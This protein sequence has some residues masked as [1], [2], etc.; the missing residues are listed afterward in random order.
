MRLDFGT[1]GTFG[2]TVRD[3]PGFTK[4]QR[5]I[6]L[7]EVTSNTIPNI[8]DLVFGLFPGGTDYVLDNSKR[9]RVMVINT[10]EVYGSYHGIS[11]T[12][13]RNVY[14][15]HGMAQCSLNEV[16][17]ETPILFT[18]VDWNVISD[19]PDSIMCGKR[20]GK[21]YN[22]VGE[23]NV[24]YDNNISGGTIY[25][26]GVSKSSE[27]L[28]PSPEFYDEKDMVL[29][30]DREENYYTKVLDNKENMYFMPEDKY[31]DTL[32]TLR[33]NDLIDSNT[34]ICKLNIKIENLSTI[35]TN[36]D[37]LENY[38]SEVCS[39]VKYALEKYGFSSGEIIFDGKNGYNISRIKSYL[40][41]SKIEQYT[42]YMCLCGE[43]D[44]INEIL[45]DDLNDYSIIM[46]LNHANVNIRIIDK[47][48]IFNTNPDLNTT[49][50]NVLELANMLKSDSTDL[51][52]CYS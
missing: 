46:T 25:R 15:H 1:R 39:N 36:R 21:K 19:N 18:D 49:D 44:N 24:S 7:S 50:T 34:K 43:I 48:K 6:I 20:N 16:N 3:I 9:T 14:I 12:R 35:K 29:I 45:V 4:A 10:S 38:L 2:K 51:L 13:T 26:T 33:L 47:V 27:I 52:N 11:D 17:G 42:D 23:V 41:L 30:S 32:Y 22:E 5:F 8:L 28:V 37:V 31:I 40:D